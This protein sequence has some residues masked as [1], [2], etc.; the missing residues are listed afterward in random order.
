MLPS[1]TQNRDFPRVGHFDTWKIDMVQKLVQQNWGY[2]FFSGYQCP[3]GFV[4]TDESFVTVPLHDTTLD[5]A[6]K[7]K[8]KELGI[9][10]RESNKRCKVFRALSLLL[11]NFQ[12]KVE[13]KS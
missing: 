8:A 1:L 2:S 5:D 12:V 4:G 7:A 10:K 3:G 11:L 9:D 6:L 13:V